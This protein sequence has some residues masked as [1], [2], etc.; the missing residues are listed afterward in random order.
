[1]FSGVAAATTKRN[2][3]HNSKGMLTP[4]DS[5]DSVWRP[6]APPSH[7]VVASIFTFLS[8]GTLRRRYD[9]IVTSSCYA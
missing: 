4:L 8:P 7:C 9:S 3:W 5:S 6:M 2:E 1:M